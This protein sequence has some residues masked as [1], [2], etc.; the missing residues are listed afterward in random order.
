MGIRRTPKL[1]IGVNIGE[2]RYR[3]TV[4]LLLAILH[5]FLV[6][7][8][9]AALAMEIALVRPGLR[10]GQLALL[11]WIDRAYGSIAGAVVL[12][13]IARVAFGLKGWEYYVWYWVFWAK[14]LAFAAIGLLSTLPTR[15]IIGWRRSAVAGPGF[16]VAEAEIGA[17]RSYLFAEVFC[18]ALVLAFA[19]AMAR[20]VGY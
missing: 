8:L 7:A 5:H 19:A 13:G 16:V 1:F 14:M 18:L 15:R 10:D 9:A 4:D 6:F 3:V 11:A 17:V 20:N 12:V 2:A